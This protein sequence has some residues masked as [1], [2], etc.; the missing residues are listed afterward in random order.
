MGV[1]AMSSDVLSDSKQHCGTHCINNHVLFLQKM[2][3]EMMFPG[4]L[5]IS[6][7][8][9]QS[10]ENVLRNHLKFISTHCV[11]PEN[12]HIHGRDFF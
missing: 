1:A 12:I 7:N 9:L 8:V 3:I 10:A 2:F 4:T 5:Q 6:E 11:V